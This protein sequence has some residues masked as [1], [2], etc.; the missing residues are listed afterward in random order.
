M[1]AAFFDIDIPYNGFR[2]DGNASYDIRNQFRAFD[3]ISSRVFHQKV[4]LEADEIFLVLTDECLEFFRIMFAGEGVRVVSVRK[5]AYFDVHAFFQ[6]HI[7]SADR[8][9]DTGYVTVIEYGNVIGETV[10]Q[11]NLSRRQCGAR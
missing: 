7:D 3:R 11:T 1:L 8:G 6:Q 2:Y 5:Q 9:F 10:D 4:G